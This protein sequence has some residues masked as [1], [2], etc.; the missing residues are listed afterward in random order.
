MHEGDRKVILLV[1]DEIS[2]AV[3]EEATLRN[4]GYDVLLA[5]A[6]KDAPEKAGR[7]TAVDLVLADV[8]RAEAARRMLVGRDVPFLF[9]VRP[10]DAETVAQTET[11]GS[12][13]FVETNSSPA[14]LDAAIRTALRLFAAH[15]NLKEENEK[16]R[17]FIGAIP[18]LM[19]VLDVDGRFES[20]E[21]GASSMLA[22]PE[23]EIVGSHLGDVFPPEKTALLLDLFRRCVE[24]GEVV[25]H[26]YSLPIEG[27]ERHFNLRISKMD[28]RRVFTII[29]DMTERKAAEDALARSRTL[30]AKM[31]KIAK[32]GGWRVDLETNRLEWTDECFA[33]YELDPGS[34]VPTVDNATR[35]PTPKSRDVLTQ[36]IRRMMETGEE[37][38]VEIEIVTAKG[39]RKWIRNI[40]QVEYV[41]GKAVA[42]TGVMQDIS[43]QKLSENALSQTTILLSTIL[44][45]SSEVTVFALDKDYRY[46]EFNSNH[47]ARIRDLFGTDISLGMNVLD[48][49]ARG[50]DR[51][52]AKANFDRA[53]GGEQFTTV[54][55][56]GDEEDSRVYWLNYFSPLV[57]AAGG[58]I[59]LTCFGLNQTEQKRMGNRVMKLLAEKETLLKEVHHRIKNNMNTMISLLN[60]QANSMKNPIVATALMDAQ[61]R[62]R[63]MQ[64]LYDKLYRNETFQAMPLDE[65]IPALLNEILR[66][67]PNGG[68]VKSVVDVDGI[69]LEVKTLSALG[70][71]VN[72]IVTN[73]MKYAFQ[74][75]AGGTITVSA[76]AEGRSVRMVVSDDGVG[77]PDSVDFE[78]STGFGLIFL[79]AAM[80][81]LDGR[82]RI[83]R[84]GGTRFVL[85]FPMK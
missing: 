48:V 12:Y 58:V 54:E 1:E 62:F 74:G 79:K 85:E 56:F 59:G 42:R 14:V 84:D 69:P 82:I 2:V 61:T 68:F 34:F 30:L 6:K 17:A 32:I 83:E 28:D 66:I 31:S 64:V 35:F 37:I 73:S 67:Y 43:K 51:E 5:T 72:E 55:E 18:D 23:D 41:G 52:A 80:R 71:I 45:S 47:R 22:L 29:R 77:I 40:G 36:A 78:N 19:F 76:K 57:D 8:D 81:Q 7:E 21:R 38:D 70:L 13:G 4:L 33:I 27:R 50:S 39:T 44:E 75:R 26:T 46:I 63:S 24:S 49:M 16:L 60:L 10:T 25:E 15:R 65:Y 11:T 53:L 20:Y 3:G 9:L